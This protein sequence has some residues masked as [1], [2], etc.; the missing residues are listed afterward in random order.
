MQ[1]DTPLIATIAV[2]LGLAFVLGVVAQRFRLPPI[3]GYLMAGIMVGPFTPGFVA[4]QKLAVEL[5]EIGVILLMFGVGLHFSLKDLLS[6]RVIA[7]PGALGQIAVA[8]LLGMGLAWTMGWGMGAGLVF[9]LALSVASTVVLLRALQER[10]QVETEKGRIAV[11][12]LIVEDLVMVVTL[13]LV[14]PLAALLGG[15]APAEMA[16]PGLAASLGV[17]PVWG[18]L[19]ITAAKLA[20]FVASMLVIGRKLIPWMLHYVAHTGS[21]ELFRLAVLAIALGVA[22]GSAKLFGVSFALGAFFAGMVLAES[23]LSHQAAKETL[24]LRDA[25]AV[26]F[27]VSV[28]MLFDPRVLANHPFAVIATFLIITVGKSVAAYLIVRAFGYS[29][30]VAMTISA[31]LAQIGEF[32]FILIV[33]AVKLAIVPQAASDFVVAGAILSILVNP[34]MF[35]AI[36]RIYAQRATG[37]A[38]VLP[39]APRAPSEEEEPTRLT[40]HAVLVGHGRV[41]SR[42]RADLQARGIAHLVVEEE[43]ETVEALKT[44]GVEA[45]LG[46]CGEPAMLERLN[47]AGARYLISAI[48][49]AFEAG[50]LVE[51]A[52]AANPGIWVVARAHSTEAVEYLRKVGADKV[53]MGEEELA[54]GMAA[55]L[56]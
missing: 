41:G 9:G 40:N 49:D 47:L 5:A 17:G 16:S 12:W 36:D 39:A 48:P 23:P 45:F 50:H 52:K 30:S 46:P 11:G 2:G 22:F 10:R 27:F 31:S 15:K 19:L 43:A 33:L 13:V 37:D 44:E 54:K 1:H 28:G 25:F 34:L 55:A 56:G 6:V 7:V 8:T 14:P 20:L 32:S 51:A 4:D 24:P 18:T 53:L 3:V 38:P 35:L 26:L 21:R 29:N 42:L